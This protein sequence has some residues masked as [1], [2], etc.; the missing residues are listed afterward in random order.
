M[1]TKPHLKH[2]IKRAG[3][4]EPFEEK[5]LYASIFAACFIVHLD[6]EKS[7]DIAEKV[8]SEVHKWLEKKGE[9][10]SQDIFEKTG[11]VLGKYS[12]DAAYMYRTHR[13]I[14]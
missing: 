7:E 6:R 3:H 9:I 13:D 11:E 14:A 8:T 1:V 12:A 10:S 4:E 2:I 5:K